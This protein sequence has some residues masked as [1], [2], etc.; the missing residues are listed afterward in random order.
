[1]DGIEHQYQKKPTGM[2][3]LD[4]FVIGSNLLNKKQYW[5]RMTM[6]CVHFLLP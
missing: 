3:Q 6:N 2:N 4:A 1:M 5:V